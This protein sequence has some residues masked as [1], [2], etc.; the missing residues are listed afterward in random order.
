MKAACLQDK[1]RQRRYAQVFFPNGDIPSLSRN[2]YR[3]SLIQNYD[4]PTSESRK[5]VNQPRFEMTSDE[6]TSRER[7]KREQSRTG[8]KRRKGREEKSSEQKKT[9]Q[10]RRE[11]RINTQEK[12]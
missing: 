4:K 6:C 5:L 2:C 12:T 7:S 8:N 1:S 11:K 3:V 9:D 10:N